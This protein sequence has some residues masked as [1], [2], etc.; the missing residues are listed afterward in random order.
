LQ[1]TKIETTK[2]PDFISG[3]VYDIPHN[4][5]IALALPHIWEEEV[6]LPKK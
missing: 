4:E 1:K 2:R 6:E 3:K 5:I